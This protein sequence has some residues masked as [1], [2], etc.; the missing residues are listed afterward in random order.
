MTCL[1]LTSLM[2]LCSGCW[3]FSTEPPAVVPIQVKAYEELPKTDAELLA[4]GDARNIETSTMKDL[5]TAVSAY[6]ELI[7]RLES[8]RST[9]IAVVDVKWRLAR[10]FFLA[11]EKAQDVSEKLRW[12]VRGEEV[13]DSIITERPDRVE[14]YYYAAVLKGRRA[15]NTSIGLSAMKLAKRVEELGLE[16]VKIDETIDDGGPLRLLAMLYAKAPP[17]PTSVGDMDLAYENARR[18]IVVADYPMN[19]LTMAEVLIEDDEMEQARVELDRVLAAPKVGHWAL[20]GEQWRPY[21]MDLRKK[22]ASD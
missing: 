6:E 7:G 13:A 20:E 11:G 10:A 12:I 14:G 18:A 5:S 15:Q 9:E 8:S 16:A 1:F 2:F 22:I 17:W 19:H 4:F 21:A 3:L